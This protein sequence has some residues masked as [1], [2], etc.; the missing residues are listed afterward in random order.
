MDFGLPRID[1]AGE[2]SVFLEIRF[3]LIG[4]LGSVFGSHLFNNLF[5]DS[6]PKRGVFKSQSKYSICLNHSIQFPKL[7]Y[8]ACHDVLDPFSK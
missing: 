1:G 4:N 7:F 8:N 5:R 3:I 6:I 2:G